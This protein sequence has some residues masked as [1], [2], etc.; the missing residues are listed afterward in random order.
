MVI[1]IYILL[2]LNNI[3]MLS[4]S[5]EKK[6]GINMWYENIDC[7]E[8]L[9][10]LYNEIPPLEKINLINIKVRGFYP[11]KVEL[12]IRLPK[13]V[14]YPP[15]KWTEKGFNYPY[16]HI[17]L[18]NVVDVFLEQHSPGD[19]ISMEIESD[20]NDGLVVKSYGDISFEIVSKNVGGLIQK[21]EGGD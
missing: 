3:I 13:S 4:K 12:I 14:D 8:F 15:L 17:D 16:I 6:N 9:K 19:E 21:I 10:R 7:T 1:I 20:G 11:Y 5:N 18:A 2:F